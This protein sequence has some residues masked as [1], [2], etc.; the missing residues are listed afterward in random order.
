MDRQACTDVDGLA[1]VWD[2]EVF[3]HGKRGRIPFSIVGD[4]ALPQG[5]F[6]AH[7]EGP[8]LAPRKQVE[9]IGFPSIAPRRTNPQWTATFV[10]D[11]IDDHD[12]RAGPEACTFGQIQ[13]VGENHSAGRCLAPNLAHLR[14]PVQNG[15]KPFKSARLQESEWLERNPLFHQ[16]STSEHKMLFLQP[17]L[18]VH[19]FAGPEQAA[20][21]VLAS[22]R[23]IA[24]GTVMPVYERM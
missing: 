6:Q 8:R 21:N 7:T 9:T 13:C 24:W 14:H 15:L 11:V 3:D 19:I 22:S 23:R 1:G 4:S 2:V 5:C 16:E 10:Y 12:C 17:Y 18:P 20:A